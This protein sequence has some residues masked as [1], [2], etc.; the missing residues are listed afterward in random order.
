MAPPDYWNNEG[1]QIAQAILKLLPNILSRITRKKASYLRPIFEF[2]LQLLKKITDSCG[3][4]DGVHHL[5]ASLETAQK[6][7]HICGYEVQDLPTDVLNLTLA[8]TLLLSGLLL[9][10]AVMSIA[11]Q[12]MSRELDAASLELLRLF[13]DF[14]TPFGI[15]WNNMQYAQYANAWLSTTEDSKPELTLSLDEGARFLFWGGVLSEHLK[16]AIKLE[17]TT[18]SVMKTAAEM[19]STASSEAMVIAGLQ[20]LGVYLE[21]KEM[22]GT[23]TDDDPALK[24]IIIKLLNSLVDHMHKSSSVQVKI[25]CHASIQAMLKCMSDEIKWVAFQTIILCPY[26]EVAGV[27][28]QEFKSAVVEARTTRTDSIFNSTAVMGV[29]TQIL[30]KCSCSCDADKQTV[31]DHAELLATT[32][33]LYRYLCLTARNSGSD[34]HDIGSLSEANISIVNTKCM[35]LKRDL[36]VH[37]AEVAPVD[38]ETADWM[39]AI[40]RLDEVISRVLELISTFPCR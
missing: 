5:V 29:I 10:L 34:E 39:M 28:L 16:G 19:C 4:D 25:Y 7:I 22:T 32:L 8:L 2:I 12:D 35:D 14:V 9:P 23:I 30:Q 26:S 20:I 21:N 38:S 15:A 27:L 37:L 3:I 24:S 31:G 6:C 18:L 40:Q 1:C 33:N 17:T 13:A 11:S 36:D